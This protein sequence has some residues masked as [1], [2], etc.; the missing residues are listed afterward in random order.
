MSTKFDEEAKESPKKETQKTLQNKKDKPEKLSSFSKDSQT[1]QQQETFKAAKSNL[2]QRRKRQRSETE[3]SKESSSNTFK[4]AKKFNYQKVLSKKKPSI[5]VA[6]LGGLNEIGKN[7][8]LFECKDS[9]FLL[10]CGMAFPDENMLGVDLVIPDFSYVK[11]NQ[12]KIKGLVITHGHE[13]HIGSIP[14]L[15]EHVNIPIYGTKLTIALISAKLKEFGILKKARLNTIVPG[16][17]VNFGYISIELIHVNHSIPDAVGVAIYS[18]AGLLIHTGDF[19]IDCTPLKEPMI[20]LG[21]FSQLGQEGVLALFADSTNAERPGYTMTEQ[22]VIESFEKL[23][24][25][26]K[27]KRIIIASFASNISRLLEIVNCAAR[28]KRKVAFSGRSMINYMTIA[29]ELGYLDIPRGVII[30]IDLLKQYPKEKIVLITTGSQGEPMSALARMASS[31]HRKI[32][33]GSDDFI[34]ISANPIPGN[35]KTIGSVVNDLIKLGCHVVYE[36]MYEVHVSGHAC[37]EELKLIQGLIKPKYFIPVH[38]EQKHLRRHADL[39]RN[40]GIPE[41]R[42]FV[43]EVGSLLEIN[44]DYMK[45]VGSVPSGKIFVDGSGVGDV[46]NLVLKERKHLSED[47]LIVIVSAMSSSGFLVSGPEIFSRGFVFVKES[48]S[49]MNEAKKRAL[50]VFQSFLNCGTHERGMLKVKL[51]DELSKFFHKNTRRNPMILPIIMNIV[52]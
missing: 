44:E 18:P 1:K 19:K 33:V 26:A 39:A 46:G 51:R 17:K 5:R 23:F 31:D 20:D 14:Y 34:I 37:Q 43:G 49:L 38:G 11:K 29:E 28:Y 52:C 10:D 8:T 13:D 27:K 12:D 6:F 36:S 15:L 25:Q 7:L 47:G 42:I 30:D 22:K 3:N 45:Q 4:S 50:E 16:Y 40:M 9:M 48:E 2:Y 21:K 35:E 41:S 32:E 24:N